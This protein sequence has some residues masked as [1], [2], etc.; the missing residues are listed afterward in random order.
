M[1][2]VL[3][4]AKFSALAKNMKSSTKKP[5]RKGAS[6]LEKIKAQQAKEEVEALAAEKTAAAAS[7]KK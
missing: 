3:A 4:M 5:L 2:G 6:I 7:Q 1:F